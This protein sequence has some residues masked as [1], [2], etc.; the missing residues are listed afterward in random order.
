MSFLITEKA[1]DVCLKRQE[2]L[3]SRKTVKEKQKIICNLCFNYRDQQKEG[4]E[5]ADRSLLHNRILSRACEYANPAGC[6]VLSGLSQCFLKSS[7]S[8][9]IQIYKKWKLLSTAK[10]A[11]SFCRKTS[12]VQPIRYLW[13]LSQTALPAA[14]LILFPVGGIGSTAVMVWLEQYFLVSFPR[15]SLRNNV[16]TFM[17][18]KNE[19]C[20]WT[21]QRNGISAYPYWADKN[22]S[23]SHASQFLLGNEALKNSPS[24]S[25]LVLLSQSESSSLVFSSCYF[26]VGL[27][28]EETAGCSQCQLAVLLVS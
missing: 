6:K 19:K 12:S 9:V 3:A 7:S 5:H 4:A 10:L 25:F 16:E 26:N 24:G 18:C 23:S 1:T 11:K 14:C 20:M 21:I 28:Q 15:A 27:G 22:L 2:W 8:K 17:V 13:W